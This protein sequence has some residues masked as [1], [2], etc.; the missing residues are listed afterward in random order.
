MIRFL[1]MVNLFLGVSDDKIY[2]LVDSYLNPWKYNLLNSNVS[3]TVATEEGVPAQKTEVPALTSLDFNK[4]KQELSKTQDPERILM[5]LQ[6]LS[7]QHNDPDILSWYYFDE[8]TG[9][10]KWRE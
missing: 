1:D 5:E 7:N 9:E 10:F 3:E 8:Q 4:V 6:E 2:F